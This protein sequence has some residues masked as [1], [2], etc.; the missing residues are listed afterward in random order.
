[1]VVAH[2]T[3]H[4]AGADRPD[5]QRAAAVDP[6]D[7]AA[8]GADLGEI[9]RRHFEGVAGARQEARAEHDAGADLVFGGTRHLAVLNERSFGGGAAHVDRDRG[10][11]RGAAPP[12]PPG[13]RVTYPAVRS[14]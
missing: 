13:I 11:P 7:R 8:A 10:T 5:L 6:Q 12:P 2:R 4:R 9:D 14:G 1:M 3:G